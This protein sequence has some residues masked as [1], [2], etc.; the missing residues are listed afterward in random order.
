MMDSRSELIAQLN[1]L[2]WEPIHE[3]VAADFTSDDIATF[4]RMLTLDL[5]LHPAVVDVPCG[6]A[7]A[8]YR[9]DCVR[10]AGMGVRFSVDSTFTNLLTV[11]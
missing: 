1:T 3:G 10:L 8:F 9:N 4:E 5:G 2:H 6:Y 7:V 11:H